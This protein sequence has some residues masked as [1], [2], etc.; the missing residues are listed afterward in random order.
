MSSVNYFVDRIDKSLKQHANELL[1]ADLVLKSDHPLDEKY[2]TLATKLQLKT[3]NATLFRS[4]VLSGNNSHLAEIKA[5]GNDYPLRGQI[6]TAEKL[7]GPETIATNI[8]QPGTVWLDPELLMRLKINIGD[9]LSLGNKEF[10]VAAILAYEPDRGSGMF[11]IAPRLLLNMVD[12]PATQLIQEG[13]RISYHFLLA[14][15]AESIARFKNQASALLSRGEKLVEV[16]DARQ[17]V[18]QALQRAQRFLGL[19]ALVSVILAGVAMAMA[20][21]S[22]VQRHMDNCA[23]MR[24]VGATQHFVFTAYLLEMIWLGIL[25]GLFGC[26][27]GY[28]GHAVLINVLGQLLVVELPAP[29][30]FPF[31]F[32]MSSGLSLLFIFVIPPLLQLKN[33]PT[34]RVIRREMGAIKATTF[35]AVSLGMAA[36]AGLLIWQAGDIK[37]GAYVFAGL[38]ATICVLALVSYLLL[39][40][41]RQ[42][43]T[44]VGVSWRFGIANI[45]RRAKSSVAQIVA[46]GIGMMALLLLSF[47]TNDLLKAWK[48]RLPADTPNRFIINIQQDQAEDVRD[49]FRLNKLDVPELF[50]MV[51][52]RLLKIN[53]KPVSAEDYEDVRAKRLVER[54]FNLSW[55]ENLQ[56]DNKIVAGRWWSEDKTDEARSKN[57]LSIEEDIA[58]TLGFKLGDK[59]VFSL[60]GEIYELQVSSVRQVSWDSFRVN[61]FALVAPGLLDNYPASYITSFYLPEIKQAVLTDLV[62]KFPNLTIVDISSIM[63][64][65]R[66][67]IL[68]VTDAV[69]YVFI[70]TL[71]AGLVVLYAAIQSTHDERIKESAML[72]T[73][74]AS[75]QQIVK[76]LMSEFITLGALSGV[77]A[78][79]ASTVLAYVLAEHIMDISYT[80]NIWLWMI[81]PLGG[82]CGVGFAGYL[83]IRKLLKQPPIQILRGVNA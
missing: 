19:A 28:L 7:F 32:G 46:F 61:F 8:P 47:V 59:L 30:W 60:A 20:I 4:M 66:D 76:G 56:E 22:Y 73:F 9:K 27:I 64:K 52:A 82:V 53:D 68:R 31:I 39:F 71:F 57:T 83:G 65:V 11:N 79:L 12:L 21:R 80:F 77:V 62:Q 10:T 67:I 2:R 44:H 63:E 41:L 49:F 24:C 81:G 14:G 51:R 36:I 29:S 55:T 48:N 23:I 25:A 17:E 75:K 1:A 40:A 54:Q 6:R 43:R 13:S 45:S 69:Q 33:V 18:R 26:L 35:S 5:V 15:E 37:L 58:K 3:V 78:A 38:L 34:M 16:T 50:P 74:G 42:L 72:R 70:F